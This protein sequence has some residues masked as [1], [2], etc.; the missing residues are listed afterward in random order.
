MRVRDFV[1]AAFVVLASVG[2]VRA[3][4]PG[5][6]EVREAVE[7]SRAEY[8]ALHPPVSRKEAARKVDEEV[9]QARAKL[10]RAYKIRSPK[11]RAAAIKDA[12]DEIAA[13]VAEANAIVKDYQPED[14]HRLMPLKLGGIAI[15]SVGRLTEKGQSADGLGYEHRFVR[16]VKAINKDEMIAVLEHREPALKDDPDS[17]PQKIESS[18]FILKGIPVTAST[19]KQLLTGVYDVVVTGQQ[20]YSEADG[21]SMQLYVLEVFNPDKPFR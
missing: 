11:Q 21:Q 5:P 13:L 1:T 6:I 7:R 16:C 12:N 20:E 10:G 3:Q 9:Q 15:G 4:R 8:K 18:R 14:R 19:E 17:E 2:A